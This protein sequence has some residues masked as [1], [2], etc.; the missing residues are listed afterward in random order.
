MRSV[1]LFVALFFCCLAP[2]LSLAQKALVEGTVT[3][4][5]IL[6]RPDGSVKEGT[7]VIAVK[8]KNVRKELKIGSDFENVTLLDDTGNGYM[9]RSVGAKN[10]AVETTP[11]DFKR[12]NERYQGATTK[13]LADRKTIAGLEARKAI[14]TYRDGSTV[15]LF[16]TDSWVPEGPVA[17]ERFNGIK[18]FPLAFDYTNEQG[19][20]ITF[21][22][23]SFNQDVVESA[24]FKVPAGYKVISSAE[25][26]QL[27][28][29]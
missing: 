21:E 23:T 12:R 26:Q 22:A 20:V 2:G 11:E 1:H 15:N 13:E 28:A 27:K 17:F 10:L 24:R 6:T 14:I 8:N 16:Y 3:Y 29:K 7:Y 18:G 9:L 25:F 5:A 19:A 4:K